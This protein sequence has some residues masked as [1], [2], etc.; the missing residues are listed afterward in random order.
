M[1]IWLYGQSPSQSSS[2][3]FGP[4]ADGNQWT[5]VSTCL[6]A[7]RPHSDVRVQFYDTPRTPRLGI[8]AVD[9]R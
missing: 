6:T 7:A 4:L 2:V 3:S 9:V 8:D 5:H 1:T